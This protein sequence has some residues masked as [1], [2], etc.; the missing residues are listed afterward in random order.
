M[1][2]RTTIFLLVLAAGGALAWW[3][4]PK[5]APHIGLV[6]RSVD[7]KGAGSLDVLDNQLTRD[8]ISRIEIK[9]GSEPVVLEKTQS[10]VWALPGNWPTRKQEADELVNLIIDLH[11]RFQLI[12]LTAEMDLKPYG[13]DKSQHPLL[14]KVKAAEGE[15]RLEFGEPAQDESSPFARPTYVQV[16]DKPEVVR[17]GP[18]LLPIL[19]RPRD[20]YQRRQL[21]PDIERVKFTDAKPP[22]PF[23][24]PSSSESSAPV[25]LPRAQFIAIEGPLGKV[26]LR[27]VSGFQ[28]PDELASTRFESPQLAEQWEITE[29]KDRPEPDRLKA[30]L[31]AIPDLWVEKFIDANRPETIA[32]Q[33][34]DS[35]GDGMGALR[36]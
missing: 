33:L 17:L 21:F 10:S 27:R 6:P 5:I 7:P 3:G 16:N 2:L 20:F 32:A 12:P 34:I 30:L 1:N 22:T 15:Y 25:S 14:V 8:S 9:A 13:L 26:S 28:K 35:P 23:G 24:P 29:P 18:D 11:S 31:A 19:K 4:A 36:D